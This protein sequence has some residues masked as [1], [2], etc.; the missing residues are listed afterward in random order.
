MKRYAANYLYISP[1]HILKNGVV[2][3]D[4]QT[5]C[6]TSVFSLDD[7]GDE[8]Q[9]TVFFNGILIPFEPVLTPEMNEMEIFSLLDSQFSQQPVSINCREKAAL[10]LLE[11]DELL[12]RRKLGKKWRITSVIPPS[13][14]FQPL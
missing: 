3:T 11:G 4:E 7:V 6:I 1:R 14:S 5:G 8:V 9:S 2:E 12:M 13:Q 10:W